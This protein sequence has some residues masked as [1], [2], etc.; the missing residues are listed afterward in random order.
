MKHLKSIS[1]ILVSIWVQVSHWMKQFLRLCA[2]C[3]MR[4]RRWTFESQTK[5]FRSPI[6]KKKQPQKPC[7]PSNKKKL[8]GNV[9][10]FYQWIH[11][12]SPFFL[13]WMKIGISPLFQSIL[14]CLSKFIL[15]III[16]TGFTLFHNMIGLTY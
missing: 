9:F 13:P 6:L 2:L 14:P 5:C 10:I 7:N 1:W 15:N 12:A 3:R 16:K 8:Y 4:N 11:F